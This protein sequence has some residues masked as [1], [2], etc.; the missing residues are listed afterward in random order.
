MFSIAPAP[1]LF[2]LGYFGVPMFFVVSGYCLTA[3]GRRAVRTGEPP[4]WFLFC[5]AVRI[6][7]PLWAA[8]L[9]A[10]VVYALLD[11]TGSALT[12][13][14]EYTRDAWRTVQ[15]GEWFGVLTLTR[16][17]RPT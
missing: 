9:L 12:P 6:Y 16:T 10:V 1:D 14:E 17:F 15:P 13:Y 11:F 8:V 3:A 7:P 5:R 2:K 4:G